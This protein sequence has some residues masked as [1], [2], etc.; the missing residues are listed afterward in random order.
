MNGVVSSHEELVHTA[1]GEQTSLDV[2]VVQL[3]TKTEKQQRL[4]NRD[5]K[6]RNMLKLV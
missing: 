4:Q 5:Q 3:N 1:L 6:A 2:I